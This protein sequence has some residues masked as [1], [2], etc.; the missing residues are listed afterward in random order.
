MGT[1][2]SRLARELVTRSQYAFTKINTKHEH[3]A[4][5][6]GCSLAD[7]LARTGRQV[8][9]KPRGRNTERENTQSGSTGPGNRNTEAIT[10]RVIILTEI[11]AAA[12][13]EQ[14]MHLAAAS[15]CQSAAPG[16]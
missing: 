10:D 13:V 15:S 1:D 14:L 16:V 5:A 12:G 9:V 7:Q 11:I 8:S 4:D 6:V 2:N 3:M